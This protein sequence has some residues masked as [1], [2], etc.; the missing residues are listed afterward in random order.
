MPVEVPEEGLR[1]SEPSSLAPI[2]FFDLLQPHY[3]VF[4]LQRPSTDHN[5]DSGQNHRPI[6]MTAESC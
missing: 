6:G 5:K 3:Q 4:V 1:S 2:A